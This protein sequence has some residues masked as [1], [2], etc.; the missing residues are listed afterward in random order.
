MKLTDF[1]SV[2]FIGIG[3]IGM[4]A[5]AKWFTHNNYTV[6]G[7]DRGRTPLIEQLIAD[8]INVHFE[9]S[10]KN[11]TPEFKDANDTL[12]VYT[13]AIPLQHKELCYFKKNNFTVLKRSEVLGL[14]TKDIETIAVAGTHGKTTTSSLLAHLLLEGGKNCTAF[15]GGIPANYQSNF[16]ANKGSL[17]TAIAVVEADEFDRSFLKLFP[18][19]A[20]ITSIDPDHLDIYDTHESLIESFQLFATQVQESGEVV[21]SKEVKTALD[22]Q[23][24]HV[25]SV[26]YSINGSEIY[27]DN[28]RIQDGKYI[29]D[30]ISDT[31]HINDLALSLPGMHNVENALAAITM[32]LSKGVTPKDIK[33]GI[34]SF[35]GIKRRFEFVLQNEKTVFIDDYAHHPLEVQAAV[36]AARQLYPTKK[37]TVVFQPHLFSRTRDFMQGFA[38]NL[39]QVDELLLLDIYA[40]REL[41]IAGIDSQHLLDQVTLKNKHLVN[42][43]SLTNHLKKNR[44]EVIMTLGAGDIDQ[45]I[46]PIKKVLMST[47]SIQTIKNTFKKL[48]R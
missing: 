39:S 19:D 20:I 47:S 38:N 25:H 3:G 34:T 14:I 11:I 21:A 32:A 37:L 41:P 16:I 30:Y 17:D 31:Q 23:N 12:I 27:T 28:L 5:L 9:D 26:C 15:L 48:T 46:E 2:Y 35:K 43:N 42:K 36:L 33:K 40:A 24:A 45:L 7:Y 29:F 8:G 13:P 22:F 10:E 1:H 6:G 18:T 44:P 4:S